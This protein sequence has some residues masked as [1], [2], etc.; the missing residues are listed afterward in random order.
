MA[1]ASNLTSHRAPRSVWEKRGWQGPTI[2]E[3]LSP[4]LVSIGGAGLFV[5]GASRR[6]WRGAPYMAV[7]AALIGS[8]AA[9][10]CNPREVGLRIQHR[11][12]RRPEMDQVAIEAMDSFPASDAPSSNATTAAGSGS[13]HG[14][15]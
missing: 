13:V 3:R 12:R 8:V 9:G 14:R 4:W 15:A 7:G 11:L 6:S 10:F 1:E 2:E 5:F